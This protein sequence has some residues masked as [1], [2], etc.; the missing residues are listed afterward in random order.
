MAR[1]ESLWSYVPVSFPPE[2]WLTTFKDIIN[3]EKNVLMLSIE[4][5]SPQKVTL[6]SVAGAIQHSESNALIKN[7]C[8]SILFT[9]AYS[10]LSKLTTTTSSALLP[11]GIKIQVPYTF[12][13]ECAYPLHRSLHILTYLQVQG[14]QS[15]KDFNIFKNNGLLARRLASQCLV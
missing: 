4:N 12:Y 11:E 6:L 10:F 14:T 3:G 2:F 15:S 13:S 8:P 5:R 1:V 7:V 9:T